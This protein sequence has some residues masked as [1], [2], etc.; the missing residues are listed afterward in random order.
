MSKAAYTIVRFEPGSSHTAV[1]RA[2]TRPLRPAQARGCEQLAY[3]CCST[4]PRP[5]IE[6]ATTELPVQRRNHQITEPRRRA[7]LPPALKL[8][9]GS[10]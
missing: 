8:L 1:R 2:T 6:L 7:K 5:G 9:P 10:T 3:G 4:A